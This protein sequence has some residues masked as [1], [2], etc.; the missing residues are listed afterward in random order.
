MH[1]DTEHNRAIEIANLC[2]MAGVPERTTGHILDGD[3]PDEVRQQIMGAPPS[4]SEPPRQIIHHHAPSGSWLLAGFVI[5][6][7]LGYFLR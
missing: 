1:N 5:G 4:Q 3:S 7:V 2:R 6:L